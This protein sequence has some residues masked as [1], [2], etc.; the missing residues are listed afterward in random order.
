METKEKLKLMSD[1]RQTVIDYLTDEQKI[2]GDALKA[3]DTT[4]PGLESDP[5]IKRMREIEAMKLRDRVHQ[6]NSYIA[7]IKRM[8]P[9]T[10]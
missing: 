1:I 10:N 2:N 5:E 8:I 7:V 6:L 9:V 4:I 3:Y